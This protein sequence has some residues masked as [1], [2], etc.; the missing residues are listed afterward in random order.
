[1]REASDDGGEAW[2]AAGCWLLAV[3]LD[4]DSASAAIVLVFVLYG[5]VVYC[6]CCP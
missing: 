5:V 4:S 1:M 2:L 3:L 6:V